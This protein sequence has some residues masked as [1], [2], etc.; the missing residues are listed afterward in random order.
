MKVIIVKCCLTCPNY[1][2]VFD[3]F[4]KKNEKLEIKD[5][6]IIHP[7]CPLNDYCKEKNNATT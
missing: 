5:N 2:R 1:S 6:L 3:G 4:C 7:K